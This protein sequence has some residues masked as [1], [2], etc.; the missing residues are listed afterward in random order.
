MTKLAITSCITK[1]IMG[2]GEEGE[3][4]PEILVSIL[5]SGLDPAW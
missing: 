3:Q 4:S 5:E 2:E 1:R